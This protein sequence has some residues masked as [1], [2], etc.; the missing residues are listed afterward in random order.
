M[1]GDI[2]TNYLVRDRRKREASQQFSNFTNQT[3]A[4]CQTL[5]EEISDLKKK[6]AEKDRDMDRLNSE[7]SLAKKQLKSPSTKA[8]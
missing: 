2:Y 6:S 8:K 4:L 3:F 7:L 1:R 5:E